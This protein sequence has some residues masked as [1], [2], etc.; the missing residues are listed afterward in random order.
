MRVN[1]DIIIVGDNPGGNVKRLQFITDS[2]D[3]PEDI[4]T[5]LGAMLRDNGRLRVTVE[6]VRPQRSSDQNRLFMLLVRRMAR[7][8]GLSVDAMKA[9]VK[10]YAVDMGYPVQRNEDGSMALDGDG[11]LVP[12]PSHMASTS[13][14]SILLD[15]CEQIAYENGYD[16]EVE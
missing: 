5:M 6:A 15:A 4:R 12:L 16:L 9:A 2:S 1:R 3:L 7:Q 13:Q 8:A 14:F 10:R 11:D